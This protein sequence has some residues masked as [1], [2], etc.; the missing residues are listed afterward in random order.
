VDEGVNFGSRYVMHVRKPAVA[1]AWDVPTSG[2]SAGATRFVLERQYGYPV[3]P[4]RAMQLGAADLSRFQVLILPEAGLGRGYAQVLGTGADR[5]KAWVSAG[6]TLIG[7]GDAISFLSDPKVGLLAVAQE[8]A[9]REGEPPKTPAATPPAA[10]ARVP[11]K[12][13]NNEADFTKAIQSDRELP[14]PVAGVLLRAR[15]TPDHWMTA[16]MG[17]T[18]YAMLS[19]RAIY[20]PVK[21]DKG[22]NAVVF[23]EPGKVL[24]SGYLWAENRK[25]LAN[26]PLVI[27]QPEGRGVVIG[28][29]ADPNY[30]AFMDGL[31]V[32]FLNAVFRGPAHA[33]PPASEE[34]WR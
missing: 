7:I 18:V 2:G 17:D 11:G 25:Q 10:D 19:G 16:G 6:G 3:T 8:N 27:V 33:R 26:K 22:V 20:T 13:L 21:L 4:I 12:L 31:N 9:Y 14:D 28:F 24:A 1:L 29:T 30:R 32:L 15:V 23:D 34:A 5:L